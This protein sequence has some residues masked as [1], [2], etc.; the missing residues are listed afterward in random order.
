MNNRIDILGVRV[1]LET[2]DSAIDKVEEHI[3]R[4]CGTEYIILMSANNLVNA[5]QDSFFKNI[6][7]KSFL[8]L[9]D[10]M[11]LVW[12]A[13]LKGVEIKTNTRGTDFFYKLCERTLSKEYKH[14]FYGGRPGIAD[15]LKDV[16]KK[17]FPG[18]QIVGTYCPPFRKLT[19]E[20]DEKICKMI[21]DSNA[22]IVWV[23]LS[24][25]K[26]ECWMSEHAGKLKVSLMVGV[27]AAF[28]FHTGVW[29]A[30]KWMQRSGLEW[31][32]RLLSEPH[33]LWRRYLIGNTLLVWWFLNDLISEKR[34][35]G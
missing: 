18:I 33:R 30:P 3:N 13:R 27:G 16:F 17:K 1:N 22:D 31:F 32:F 14:F 7:N 23:G 11:F 21:S 10:G 29:Q 9:P 4:K 35:K 6:C 26:Q 20:E 28:D 24:T 12:A 2:Y 15:E 19:E 34:R 5:K 8:S 25:P